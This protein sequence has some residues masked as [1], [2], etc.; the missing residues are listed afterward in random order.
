MIGITGTVRQR[1]RA[2]GSREQFPVTSDLPEHRCAD[3]HFAERD[4]NYRSRSAGYEFDDQTLS[5]DD[6][7][8]LTVCRPQ[9]PLRNLGFWTLVGRW[10]LG[11]TPMLA[12]FFF[13]IRKRKTE[14]RF[15]FRSISAS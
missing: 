7:I 9:K 12:Q 15:P 4:L 8:A 11:R 2:R 6:S 5:P 13:G 14:A 3:A 10:P 1:N